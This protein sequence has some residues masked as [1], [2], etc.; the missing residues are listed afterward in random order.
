MK[1]VLIIGGFVFA[2]LV[3]FYFYQKTGGVQAV[4]FVKLKRLKFE[5]VIPFPQLTLVTQ[6]NAV[7]NNPNPFGVEIIK[8]DFDVFVE[9][10]LSTTVNQA[11]SI[12]MPA[13][14]E[15]DLPISFE[16]PIGKSGFFNH[17]KDILSGAWKNKSIKIR[18]TGKITIKLLKIELNVPFDET[19]EYLLKDYLPK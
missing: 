2:A 11:T 19:E 4:E 9:E 3:S 18:T 8:M 13:N 10:K 7:L 14:S 12:P 17:A 16:I 1:R 6:A 15:F 5:K